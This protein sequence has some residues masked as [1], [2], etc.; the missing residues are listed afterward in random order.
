M[1]IVDAKDRQALLERTR[2]IVPQLRERAADAVAIRRVPDE[3]FRAMREAGSLKTIQSLRNGGHG[4][5]M[6]AHLDTV[7]TLAEGCGSTAWCAG[8]IQAHSWLVS[9]FPVEAQDEIY[10]PDPDTVVAAVVGPRGRAVP[11]ADGSSYRL[12][13]FWPFASGNAGSQWILLGGVVVDPSDPDGDAV[14]DDGEFAVP[15]SDVTIHDDWHVAGLA[16]TG[17]CSVS[18][19]GAEVPAH[20]FLSMRGVRAD[21]GGPGTAAQ[22]PDDWNQWSPAVPVLALAL[23]GGAIGIARR[24]VADFGGLIDDKMIAYTPH[25]QVD[26]PV[27]HVQ[28]GEAAMLA[29]EGS[30]TLY[31]CADE[32]DRAGRAGAASNGGRTGAGSDTTDRGG[33]GLDPL[34]HARMRLDCATG[35]RRC[36]EAVEILFKASGG[37]GLRSDSPLTRAVADL[38][39]INQHGMLNLETNRELYGRAVLGLP[40]LGPPGASPQRSSRPITPPV[41]PGG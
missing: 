17:S 6:R 32:I 34:T 12:S 23:T 24:A 15:L 33:I 27:T 11:S 28:V 26:H 18:L 20:R 30:R 36:L 1:T 4:G 14:I 41:R 22:R 29:H 10:G 13:G 2:A 21:E 3:N 25:R 37:S 16:G 31:A 7:S 35:V 8:V 9:H 19:D 38:R 39:G 5:S 40:P